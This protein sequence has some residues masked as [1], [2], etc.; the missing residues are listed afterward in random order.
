[1]NAPVRNYAKLASDILEIVG[2]EHN[3]INLARCATRLRLVLKTALSAEKKEE[4]AHLTGVITVVEKGGQLQIVIGTHV[5]KV[6][7]AISQLVQIDNEST[8]EVKTSVLNRVIATMSAVFAPFIYILAAAGILQ[9]ILIIV[10]MIAPSFNDTG[11]GIVFNFISWTPFAF[12]PVFIA[13]TASK[14]FKCNLFI[15]VVCCAALIN[16]D[17]ANNIVNAVKNNQPLDFFGLPFSDTTY[18]SSVLPPLFLVWILSYLERFLNKVINDVIKPLFTPLLCMVIMVPLTI[19]LIGPLS[20]S[21]AHWIAQGYNYLVELSPVV[22]GGIIGGIW[23]IFVIFGVHWGITPVVMANFETMQ[24]DSFQAFQTIAVIAQIGA[25]FGFFLRTKMKDLKG[26]S[27][28]ASLTGLFGITEPAI[29]GVNLRFKRPFIYGCICGAIGG[30]VAGFFQPYYY[31]YAGLPGPLTIIN[32]YNAENINSIIGEVIGCFIGLIGPILL[33]FIFGT[34]ESKATVNLKN[35]A[36]NVN[37]TPTEN[38]VATVPLSITSPMIGELKSPTEVPDPVFAGEMMGK[39]VAI[40]PTENKV[41]APFDGEVTVLFDKSKHAIGLISLDGV[42]LLI[43]VGIDTVRLEQQS[44]EKPFF[45]YHVALNQKV[46]QGDLLMSFDIE[47]IL[48]T[49]CPIITPII[50]TNSGDY[51]NIESSQEMPVTTESIIF[52]IK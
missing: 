27:F 26:V 43:H 31:A 4:I 49:G 10:H 9:G 21:G 52:N 8:S 38:N 50:I 16:P 24:R 48:A 39:S 1:M 6:F 2:G 19:L 11:A 40:M 41:Y 20:S 23:E 22:A 34:G 29:Y 37:P 17:F 32:S 47:G 46:N 45:E 28:S 44:S 5:D 25:V 3:I 12:L 13:I 7:D 35:D 15:A 33:I 30:I 14:H 42:E 36:P 18:A 51:E